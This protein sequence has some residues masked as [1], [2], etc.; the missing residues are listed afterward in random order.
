MTSTNAALREALARDCELKFK[1]AT[2]LRES[3]AQSEDEREFAEARD[4][5]EALNANRYGIY[6]NGSKWLEA[7]GF[8]ASGKRKNE[9]RI[10]GL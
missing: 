5:R 6:Q 8:T 4:T 1:K 9:R 10:P 2:E 3:A 7:H